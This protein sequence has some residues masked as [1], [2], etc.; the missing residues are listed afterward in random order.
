MRVCVERVLK[1]GGRGERETGKRVPCLSR[2]INIIENLITYLLCAL[3][4]HFVHCFM[5][6]KTERERKKERERAR[7]RG[8]PFARPHWLER[9]CPYVCHNR[10]IFDLS[11]KANGSWPSGKFP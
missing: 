8:S 11:F 9:Y 7:E 2:L 5:P 3:I 4:A 1:C 10:S 6:V